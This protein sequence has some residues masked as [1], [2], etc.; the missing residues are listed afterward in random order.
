MMNTLANS[1][2]CQTVH[3]T[4]AG[5]D[6]ASTIIDA[7]GDNF[8]VAIVFGVGGVIAILGIIFGSMTSISKNKETEK[9]KRELAAYVAE[10]SMTPSDAERLLKSDHEDA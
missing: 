3:T 8:V 5:N 6:N 2:L 7:M 9:T 10:G 1:Q 4:L